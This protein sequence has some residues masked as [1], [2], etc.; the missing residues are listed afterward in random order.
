MEE[1]QKGIQR[2]YDTAFY[3]GQLDMIQKLI[4]FL[5]KESSNIEKKNKELHEA[6]KKKND[7]K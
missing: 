2:V 7:G 1:F 5:S 3:A 4:S 6:L